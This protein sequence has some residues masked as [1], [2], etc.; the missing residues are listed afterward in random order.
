MRIK[1]EEWRRFLSHF[2][3]SIEI[4]KG[5]SKNTVESYSIDLVRYV[6]F[7]EDNGIKHPDF[8][9][10][11]LVRKYIREIGLI[12]LSPSSISRNVASIKSFHKFLLLESYSKNYPVENIEHPKIKKKPPEVLSI[13]E[14]FT[15][16]EQPDT[17]T[18]IGIRDRA[19]LEVMYAT[20]V[21]VSELINLKQIDLFLDMEFIR[22]LGKGSKERLIPI[23][24]V[25]IKWVREYQL[26]VRPKLA[27][28]SSGDI[29]FL[30]RLGK[31]LTRMSVWKIVKKY[32]LMAGIR[33]EIHPHTLR[34]SF[35]THLLEGGSDLRSVQE[36]LGHASITTTQIYTHISNETLRE[37]YYLYHPRSN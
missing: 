31:K 14:V 7:L 27:K 9:D 8:V 23:G 10:E 25:A 19:L 16:L 21:R 3:K 20:G 29:L 37:I 34:H 17:S 15:L 26:K 18:P 28:I 32:A 30:S 13:D 12:G 6:C 4:E 1:N 11:E 33:K 35:A 22:V 24:K 36:M 2:L 5:Y